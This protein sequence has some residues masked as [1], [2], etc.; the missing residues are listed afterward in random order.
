M[1]E[2]LRWYHYLQNK[3]EYKHTASISIMEKRG[4]EGEA[5]G[6]QRA[7][8]V[9]ADRRLVRAHRPAGHRGAGGGEAP[10]R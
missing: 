4:K 8:L 3:I 9:R 6:V 5:E 7:V 1:L 10:H 2:R